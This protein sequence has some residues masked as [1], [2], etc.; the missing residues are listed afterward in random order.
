[1]GYRSDVMAIIYPEAQSKLGEKTIYEQLKVLMAT[2]FKDVSDEFGGYMEWMDNEHVLKFN[3][4]D[5]KWYPSYADVQMFEA[6]LSAFGDDIPGYCTEFVRVG[7]EDDD[8][9][10]RRTGED[11]QYYLNVRRSIDCNV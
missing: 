1:M 3:L 11:N 2:T 10:S 8:T 6:M 9:E 7:E 4:P 5:V